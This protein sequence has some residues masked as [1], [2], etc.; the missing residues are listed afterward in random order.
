VTGFLD[1]STRM[2]LNELEPPKR[3]F[4]EFFQ[5]FLMQRTFQHWIA[6]KWLEIDQDNLRI[7]FSA[8]N[9]EFS[10]PSREPLGIKNRRMLPPKVAVLPQL[11]SSRRLSVCPS[12]RHTRDLYQNG[13]SCDH[14]I[15]NVG[16]PKN[17]SLSWQNSVPLGGGFPRTRALKRGT[18]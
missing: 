1:L 13:G 18:P 4:S 5:K 17:F 11:I 7:K 12:V 6:T 3:G 15:F 14:K 10:S 16:F 2:T 8:S 9:V